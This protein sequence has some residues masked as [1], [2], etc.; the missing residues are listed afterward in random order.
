MPR[1]VA[2][3]WGLMRPLRAVLPPLALIVL[4]GAQ[5]GGL[6]SDG[7]LRKD[8][9]ECEEAVQHAE[10]C[11]GK[12]LTIACTYE[13]GCESGRS[14]HPQIPTARAFMVRTTSCAELVASG[15]CDDPQGQ[16]DGTRRDAG[17]DAASSADLSS[18]MDA[19]RGSDLGPDLR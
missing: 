3:G 6:V 13:S 9:F 12:A 2:S 18:K 14:I 10:N 7:S 16:L 17:T 15:F 1:F 5:C 19:D 4:F 11:C 8:V